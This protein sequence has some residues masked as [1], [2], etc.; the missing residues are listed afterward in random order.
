MAV[1]TDDLV[2]VEQASG[3]RN[4]ANAETKALVSELVLDRRLPYWIGLLRHNDPAIR[5]LA[6]KRLANLIDEPVRL[7]ANPPKEGE[8]LAELGG[9]F[10]IEQEYARLMNWL[11]ENQSRLRWDATAGKYVMLGLNP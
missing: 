4:D 2:L 8:T 5:S 10:E 11:D 9:M 3:V 6:A 1:A 7:P